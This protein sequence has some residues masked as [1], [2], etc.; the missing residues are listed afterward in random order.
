VSLALRTAGLQAQLRGIGGD[1]VG[2]A[3]LIDGSVWLMLP[4][5]VGLTA[6]PLASRWSIPYSWRAAPMGNAM[7]DA[8][9]TQKDALRK[10]IN[11]LPLEARQREFALKAAETASAE[12]VEYVIAHFNRLQEALPRAI[13]QLEEIRLASIARAE[14]RRSKPQGG[15]HQNEAPEP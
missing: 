14:Q 9:P 1:H 10:V 2:I 4:L 5:L 7:S 13:N 12:H 8:T 15:H 6:P 3:R 11:S